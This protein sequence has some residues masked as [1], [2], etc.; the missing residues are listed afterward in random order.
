MSACI[1]YENTL[2]KYEE[3]KFK[4]FQVH[5][6]IKQYIRWLDA[7]QSEEFSGVWIIFRA[8][9]TELKQ[10]IVMDK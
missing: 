2:E 8:S 9:R 10:A 4:D 6:P 3:S 1:A 7:E 5:I